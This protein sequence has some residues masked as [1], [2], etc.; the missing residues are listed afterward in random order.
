[1]DIVLQTSGEENWD[2]LSINMRR[3]E[4][5]T[6]FQIGLREHWGICDLPSG[7][8]VGWGGAQQVK[9]PQPLPL[10][11]VNQ[12]DSTFVCFSDC[13]ILFVQRFLNLIFS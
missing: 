13:K 10:E 11:S 6:A 8:P 2:S 12:S 9:L 5:I 7:V 3:L 4:Q 1:M